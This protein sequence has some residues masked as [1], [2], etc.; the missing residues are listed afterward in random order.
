MATLVLNTVGTMFGGPIGGAIG[1][2]VGQTIDQQLLGPGARRGPRLGDL[3]VQGS[4]YGSAIPQIFGTMRVAGTLIWATDLQ[5]QAH[6]ES[7]KGQPDTVTYSYSASFAFALSSR[8]IIDVGRI[9]ADG[10]LIRD[11]SGQFTVSTGFRVQDGS[12]EQQLDPL[13]ASIEGIG[14]APAY[15]G[16]ALAVFESFQLAE[17]GNR[18]PFFTFEIIAD[19]GLVGIGAILGIVSE[20]VIAAETAGAVDGYAAYGSTV[21]TAVQPL[22]DLWDVPLFDDGF[23]LSTG[24]PVSRTIAPEEM[25]STA[26]AIPA[27]R[28]ER[29]QEPATSL[30]ASATLSY[31]DRE[32]DYQTG[33]ARASVDGRGTVHDQ[34]ELPAVLE[35]S[36]AKALIET[37][38]ARRWAERDRLTLRLPP[39]NLDSYPGMLLSMPADASVWRAAQVTIDG[40]AVVAEL[41]PTYGVVGD[42][43]ADAGRVAAS[44]A[45]IPAPTSL[46]ILELPDAGTGSMDAPVVVIAATSTAKIWRPVPLQ[47]EIGGTASDVRSA[48][49]A[50]IMGT[51]LT[52]LGPGQ[53]AVLDLLNSV[54]VQLIRADD[55]LQSRDDDALAAGDNLAMLG[56]ELIQFGDAVP[57]GDGRFR[58]SR[59]LRGRRG[60]EWAM[61]SH[62]AGESFAMLDAFRLQRVPLIA[63]QQGAELR[64]TP[65]GLA[66]HAAEPVIASIA[67]EAM[68]PPSPVRLAASWNSLGNLS[69]TWV[70]RSSRGW[71]WL[72]NV[73]APLGCSTEL[74]RITVTGFGGSIERTST[75]PKV[76]FTAA[77]LAT[78]GNGDADLSVVQVGDLAVS[79]PAILSI[80]INQD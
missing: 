26:E 33:V 73:E 57:L 27:P 16:T 28:M 14:S 7:A 19:A 22:V 50:T 42:V 60:T 18:I 10:K 70:R 4:S 44:T 30:P 79:R 62:P 76:E 43:P 53:S 55:W 20:G 6:T 56:R 72:D 77:E 29:S 12:E 58:L 25:G 13:I 8:R 9:W 35:A 78:I 36:A 32:R 48:R 23:F 69:C 71:S 49:A 47:L 11:P 24:S 5:E 59:L 34:I 40:L 67:G 66:D 51:A 63:E 21:R 41:R 65:G 68:R 45:S 61:A 52:A 2:L 3:S 31:Y 64:V 54:D 1:S 15:R 38:L 75:E 80:T 74:Y 37:S 39:A 17:F 46:A